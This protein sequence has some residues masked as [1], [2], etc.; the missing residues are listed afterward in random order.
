MCDKEISLQSVDRLLLESALDTAKC[1]RLLLQVPSET[2]TCGRFYY[3]VCQVLQN[4]TVIT[5]RVFF[6][7]TNSMSHTSRGIY[8]Q[9]FSNKPN[10]LNK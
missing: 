10:Y 1:E 8:K 4:V 2:T 6:F 9:V 5:K 3:K 7:F